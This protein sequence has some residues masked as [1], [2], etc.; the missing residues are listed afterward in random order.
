MAAN[1]SSDEA[2]MITLRGREGFTVKV[3]GRARVELIDS[4]G[5][6]RFNFGSLTYMKNDWIAAAHAV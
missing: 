1:S 5:E 3:T 2:G 4:L 6:E